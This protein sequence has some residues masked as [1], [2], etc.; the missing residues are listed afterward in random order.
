MV[1]A[2]TTWDVCP[3]SAA[4]NAGIDSELTGPLLIVSAT[5]A[6][7]RSM[8]SPGGPWKKWYLLTRKVIAKSYALCQHAMT[9]L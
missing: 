9:F 5:R 4:V 7:A 6:I 2:G 3:V 8:A 1:S